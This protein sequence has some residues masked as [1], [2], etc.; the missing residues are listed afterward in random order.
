MRFPTTIKYHVLLDNTN[1]IGK[2]RCL[3]L[4]LFLPYPTM[5]T[6]RRT[7]LCFV[8]SVCGMGRCTIF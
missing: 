7:Q 3:Q 5:L 4:I 2:P 6:D 8:L 1:K